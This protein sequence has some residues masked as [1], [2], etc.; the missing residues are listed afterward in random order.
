MNGKTSRGE[1]LSE[2]SSS[3]KSASSKPQNVEMSKQSIVSNDCSSVH[4]LPNCSPPDESHKTT[5]ARKQPESMGSRRCHLINV[6]KWLNGSLSRESPPQSDGS[7][8]QK[9]V[10]TSCDR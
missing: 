9:P 3:S 2:V 4:A 7:G 6:W 5:P 8:F 1:R 10:K